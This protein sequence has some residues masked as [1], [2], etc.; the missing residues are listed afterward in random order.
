[1]TNKG[2]YSIIGVV[3]A[4]VVIAGGS[5]LIAA[6]GDNDSVRPIENYNTE[7]PMP[8]DVEDYGDST[9]MYNG[10]GVDAMPEDEVEDMRD[11]EEEGGDMN[12]LTPQEDS[13]RPIENEDFD[14]DSGEISEGDELQ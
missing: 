3:V 13:V 6:D 8:S 9:E 2:K 5:F 14:D 1:M 4:F 12:D 11:T 7:N 10:E